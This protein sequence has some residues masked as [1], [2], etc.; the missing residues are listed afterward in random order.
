MAGLGTPQHQF[1]TQHLMWLF[2]VRA[3]RTSKR[4]TGKDRIGKTQDNVTGC[5][6]AG[7][8]EPWPVDVI[9]IIPHQSVGKG[10]HAR[11]SRR[12]ERYMW[13]SAMYR[14]SVRCCVPS[15]GGRMSQEASL[16]GS[17]LRVGKPNS[18]WLGQACHQSVRWLAPLTWFQLAV[19][20]PWA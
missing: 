8:H 2:A 13:T 11:S 3:R 6:I 10:S 9:E 4:K 20:P 7:R 14:P 17:D 15:V 1:G 12:F 16:K 18:G 19:S 5:G